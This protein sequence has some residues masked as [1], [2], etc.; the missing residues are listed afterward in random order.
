LPTRRTSTEQWPFGDGKQLFVLLAE[1]NIDT[2]EDPRR[3]DVTICD[4]T[5]KNER[6]YGSGLKEFKLGWRLEP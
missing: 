3:A 4:P 5:A 2:G 1:L 6:L